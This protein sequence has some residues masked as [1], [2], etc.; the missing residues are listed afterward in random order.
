[1]HD[2]WEYIN[3]MVQLLWKYRTGEEI[4]WNDAFLTKGVGT[5]SHVQV[6]KLA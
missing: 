4:F 1:M 6:D 5:A 2:W 3:K